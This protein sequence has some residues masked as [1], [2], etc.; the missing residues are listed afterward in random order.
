VIVSLINFG[1]FAVLN[2]IVEDRVVLA[3]ILL[4][5]QY[6]AF[7]L[8]HFDGF[9]DTVDGVFSFASRERRLEILRD[10]H[11]GAFGLFFG[12]LYVVCKIHF[13]QRSLEAPGGV[14]TAILLAYPLSGR[15]A[16]ALTATVMGPAKAEGLGA[17]VGRFSWIKTTAGILLACLPFCLLFILYP[18]PLSLLL[19]FTGGPAACVLS[20]LL[21][22]KAIGGTTGDGLGFSIE[23]GELFH[24][25]VFTL[26]F[27]PAS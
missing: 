5:V 9:V 8:F 21:L 10:V 13:L 7:N 23:L 3:L 20:G 1:L 16:A 18:F 4:G 12:I 19:V 26:C 17:M 6:L 11:I 24:L 15:V 2:A 22:K 25:G 27:A 14:V